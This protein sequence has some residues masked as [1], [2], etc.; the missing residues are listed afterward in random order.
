VTA[1]TSASSRP[2]YLPYQGGLDGFQIPPIPE[3]S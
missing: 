2:A 1:I 3:L